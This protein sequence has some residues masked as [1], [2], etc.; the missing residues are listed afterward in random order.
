MKY[1]LIVGT[2][3]VTSLFFLPQATAQTSCVVDGLAYKPS[4]ERWHRS[5]KSVG[6]QGTC[7]IG[8]LLGGGHIDKKHKNGRRDTIVFALSLIHI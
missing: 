7:W 3:L 1:V 8:P 2:M 4:A 6:V 5:M